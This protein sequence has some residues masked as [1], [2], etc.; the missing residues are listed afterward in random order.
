VN[1]YLD[2][3]AFLRSYLKR[4]GGVELDSEFKAASRSATASVTRVEVAASLT[5]LER[6]GV[7]HRGDVRRGIESLERDMN[8]AAEIQITSEVVVRAYELVRVHHLRGYDGIQLAA[9]DF[10]RDLLGE[11]VTFATFD[12]DLW[13]AANTAGF[14]VWPPDLSA[15]K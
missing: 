10:W 7:I 11:E 14:A 1:L 13:G 9:A 5:R 15:F 8:L 3:S 4:K 6:G 12:D 2:T